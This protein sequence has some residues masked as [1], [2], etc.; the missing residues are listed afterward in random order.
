MA[1]IE[2]RT[3]SKGN[4]TYRVKI[5]VKGKPTTSATFPKLADAKQW[6]TSTEAAIREGRYKQSRLTL[7][8]LLVRYVKEI[9]PTYSDKEQA[10]RLHRLNFWHRQL[11]H[12]YL[13]DVTPAAISEAKSR[14]PQ[15][16]ATVDKYLKN[17]SHVFSTAIEE[18]HVVDSNP[19]SRV[20]SPKLPR[21]RVR[22][23]SDD[24][25]SRLLKACQE[26]RNKVLYLCVSLAMATGM[27]RSEL[28]GLTWDAVNLKDG[29]IILDQT[30]NGERRRVPLSSPILAMFKEHAKIRSLRSPLCFPS[31]ADHLSPID[32]RGP[33]RCALERAQIENFKW[34]DLR[35]CTASYLAMNGASLAEIAEVLGHKTLAMVKRYAHLSDSHV[36]GVVERMN[37]R[38]FGGAG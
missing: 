24:E 16:A 3:D 20:K 7:Q 4:T 29:Y 37:E 6:A 14:L 35:H 34:H 23:L 30:K 32:L 15:S 9:V 22:Y 17:L 36:G 8:E 18:W 27:R 10:D 2:T 31:K 25:R 5:R 1:S 11:G 21:G 38:I 12:L 19:V 33:F 26:S 13:S 28:M